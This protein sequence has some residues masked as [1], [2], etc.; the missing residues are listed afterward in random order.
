MKIPEKPPDLNISDL[1]EI[2]QHLDKE[3]LALLVKKF[4]TK[5]LYWSDFKYK[6]IPEDITPEQFWTLLKINRNFNAERIKIS[7]VPGFE[8]NYNLTSDILEKLH[9]FDLNLAGTLEG[10]N[11]TSKEDHNRYLINSIIEE[12]IASSQLEG[13]STSRKIAKKC[14][15]RIGSLKITLNR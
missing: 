12:A 13:A 15:N 14:S 11:L 3:E 4:N 9:E 2:L 10:Q 5:Y 6:K 8:F 7:N 1:P